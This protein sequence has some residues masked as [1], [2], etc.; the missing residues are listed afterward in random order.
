MGRRLIAHN[1]GLLLTTTH[2]IEPT[3]DG[4]NIAHKIFERPTDYTGT[5][6]QMLMTIGASLITR[7]GNRWY[8]EHSDG[9]MFADEMNAQLDNV[10]SALDVFN[11]Q[12]KKAPP[13]APINPELEDLVWA[14]VMTAS[15]KRITGGKT[16]KDMMAWI[17]YGMAHCWSRWY[18]E[19]ELLY[20][21]FCAVGFA[22]DDLIKSNPRDG[23][24]FDL[25]FSLT[26][27]TAK[28]IRKV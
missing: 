18:A 24:V 25:G 19:W 14:I 16:I 6:E 21:T 22:C 23:Q 2:M 17:R 5:P 12:L 7:H 11:W 13:I 1:G 9:G 20:K 8:T 3:R 10:E 4:F 26:R 27:G 28:I 15:E